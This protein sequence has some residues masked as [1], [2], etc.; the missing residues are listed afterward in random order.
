[1]KKALVL[2]LICAVAV[3]AVLA[4]CSNGGD[5]PSSDSSSLSSGSVSGEAKI[6][7]TVTLPYTH[8]DSLNPYAAKSK[9]NQELGLLLYDSLFVSD[10][11][12]NILPG[13]ASEIKKDTRK[14]TV[15]LKDALFT[16]GTALTADDVVYSVERIKEQPE[17]KYFEGV[18]VIRQCYAESSK[19]VVFEFSREC[20]FFEYCLMFPIIK[21][22][23]ASLK[24]VDN[25]EL[26]P[27][28]SG[29]YVF[30]K[31]ASSVL[32][33][34]NES[35]YG[36]NVSVK[37]IV[38]SA[39]PDSAAVDHALQTGTVD[40]Y[41][42]DLS[43]NT[44]PTLL[45]GKSCSVPRQNLV[46]LGVGKKSLLSGDKYLRYA[47]SAAVDRTDIVKN[48]YFGQAEAAKGPYHS[49]LA[50]VQG[51]QILQVTADKTSA[52]ENLELGGYSLG[53]NGKY[54]KNG[55]AV[56]LTVVYNSE[57][58]TREQAA[59]LI[60]DQLSRAGIDCTVKAC[61]YAE[62]V[63][64]IASGW[65][66]LYIAEMKLNR[67]LDLYPV[68]TAG[69]NI[70]FSQS[71]LEYTE[72]EASTGDSS[73]ADKTEKS[74]SDS[75]SGGASHSD[76]AASGDGTTEATSG[77][78]SGEPDA[79]ISGAA[80]SENHKTALQAAYEYYCKN[81]SLSEMLSCFNSEIPFI[82]LCHHNA[83]EL[84]SPRI[85]GLTPTWYDP[86]YGIENASVE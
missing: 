2:R 77:Q 79:D 58:T 40:I 53:E 14:C 75:S 73:S 20:E 82:P 76:D 74:T 50:A 49:S 70:S 22:G 57:N 12:F 83:V 72:P 38:L 30:E 1:M 15:T 17:C 59:K 9:N 31:S 36:G 24:D 48:A 81:G 6:N 39:L 4:S 85:N 27:T 47:V 10:N 8:N 62:Y 66:D 5:N 41:Y 37:E 52:A 60:C 63:S 42:S 80:I 33:R 69:G 61:G 71:E 35:W 3:L 54:S 18:S 29:R 25:K 28:G 23:T 86:F 55:K 45:S 65:C 78:P 34:A 21:T 16:D 26:P 56:S 7:G 51:Q 67:M 84:Y 46:Y 64:A 68:L 13:L 11:S 19:K 32:L 44:M 43:D